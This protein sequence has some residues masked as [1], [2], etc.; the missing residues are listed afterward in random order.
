M[1]KK[2]GVSCAAPYKHFKDTKEFIA[3]ILNYI[4][5]MYNERQKKTLQKYAHCDSRTQLLQVSLDYIPL[6]GGV[7]GVPADHHAEL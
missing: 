1:A 6:F 3:Q 2:C 5:Q 7:S 4:N